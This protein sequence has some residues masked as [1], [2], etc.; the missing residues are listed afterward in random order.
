LAEGLHLVDD[1]SELARYLRFRD[2]L[3][4]DS[5]TDV[6]CPVTTTR[7]ATPGCPG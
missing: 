3:R 1:L 4:A 7:A 6:P 2:R 5:V